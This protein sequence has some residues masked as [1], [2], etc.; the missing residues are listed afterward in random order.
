MTVTL[1]RPSGMTAD[2]EQ[3]YI[4]NAAVKFDPYGLPV[5]S[6]RTD[7]CVDARL[8]RSISLAD[9]CHDCLDANI[10]IEV[11]MFVNTGCPVQS[12]NKLL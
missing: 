10:I 11:G 6:P 9:V 12:A 2:S 1:A 7:A 5:C 8:T 4:M 3:R